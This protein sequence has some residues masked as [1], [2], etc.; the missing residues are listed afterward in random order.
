VSLLRVSIVVATDADPSTVLDLAQE[1]AIRLSEDCDGTM[2]ED[3]L[4]GE[5][6]VAA[7][8]AAEGETPPRAVGASVDVPDEDIQDLLSSAMEGGSHYW[9]HIKRYENPDE[10]ETTYKHIE[11]PLTQ[12]GAVVCIESSDRPMREL[13]EWRLDR[14]A[15]NLGL[16]LMAEQWPDRWASFRNETYDADDGDC[17]LQLCLFG[18]VIYG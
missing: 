1:A 3:V 5:V 16:R 15:V 6:S 14:A 7:Y 10:E 2:D 11:L 12:R 17:F 8:K 18:E 4:A 9:C 13:P